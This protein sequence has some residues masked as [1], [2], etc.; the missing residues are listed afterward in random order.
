MENDWDEIVD[1][2]YKQDI[3]LLLTGKENGIK[4][5]DLGVAKGLLFWTNLGDNNGDGVDELAIVID[6]LD[7][8]RLNSCFIYSYC[9]HKW[10]LMFDFSIHESAFDNTDFAHTDIPGYLTKRKGMWYYNDYIETL[11]DDKRW[12]SKQTAMPT[13]RLPLQTCKNKSGKRLAQ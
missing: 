10:E 1:W 3:S 2:Y 5:L 9:N 11:E 4:A 7:Y 6:Y 13:L 8:S 12:E